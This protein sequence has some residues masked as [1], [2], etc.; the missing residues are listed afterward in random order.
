MDSRIATEY[1][2]PEPTKSPV[3]TTPQVYEKH[4]EIKKS[5]KNKLKVPK[6]NHLNKSFNLVKKA[7]IY[8]NMSDANNNINGQTPYFNYDTNRTVIGYGLEYQN[9]DIS[10]IKV[11][12]NNYKIKTDSKIVYLTEKE[13][14]K[15]ISKLMKKKAK[16]KSVLAH[17][18]N[19][20]SK[21]SIE[22]FYNIKD[23]K[24]KRI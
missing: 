18:T 4:K 21:N 17:N 20:S 5:T 8:T 2:T 7:T 19:S 6:L 11:G 22:G 23:I 13:A 14:N 3:I 16:M 10:I 1:Q 12:D 24:L 9:K 15:Y